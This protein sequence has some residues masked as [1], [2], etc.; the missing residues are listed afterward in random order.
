MDPWSA[1]A[2]A[3]VYP[4]AKAIADAWFEARY[5]YERAIQEKPTDEDRDRANRFRDAVRMQ[6]LPSP[7][8]D[9]KLKDSSP[10]G[11]RD[12]SDSL[13]PST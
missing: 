13:R 3:V 10:S 11:K 5:T 8:S 1:I 4:I 12:D 9:P 6:S 7:G 2:K